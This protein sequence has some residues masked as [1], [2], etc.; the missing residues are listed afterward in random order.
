MSI[1]W[2]NEAEILKITDNM[3][4]FEF[5]RNMPSQLVDADKLSQVAFQAVNPFPMQKISLLRQ[6]HYVIV[7]VRTVS[8]LVQST[9]INFSSQVGFLNKCETCDTNGDRQNDT[10]LYAG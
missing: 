7:K 8:C 6:H 5:L 2:V 3:K 4:M 10:I 1:F 9:L